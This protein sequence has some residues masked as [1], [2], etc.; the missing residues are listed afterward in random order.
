MKSMKNIKPAYAVK[1]GKGVF[2][3]LRWDEWYCKYCMSKPTSG[4]GAKPGTPGRCEKSPT[5]YHVW[6]HD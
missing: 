3:G 4:C 2:S 5:G 6:E 1:L